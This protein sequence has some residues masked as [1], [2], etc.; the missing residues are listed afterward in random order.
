MEGEIMDGTVEE[1]VAVL[2]KGSEF[3][4]PEIK[5]VMTQEL[6]ERLSEA[7]AKGRPLRVYCGYDATRPDLHLGHTITLRKLRQFQAFGHEATFLIGDFT[8]RVG[9]PSDRDGSRPQLD[10]EEI[11][12]NARTYAEQAFKI[13]DPECTRV[14]YNSEWLAQLDLVDAIQIASR[15][16]VQQ[17]LARENFQARLERRDPIWLHEFFY[18]LF[19]GYDAVAL[20]T[21]VQLGAT[22]QL[23]NLL[24]GRKLQE[25]FGQRPQVCI[26]FPVLVGT[27]GH[28]RMSK[29][30]GNYIGIAEPPQVMYGKVMSIPDGAMSSYFRLV[31]RWSA[32]RVAQLEADL[33]AGH[34]HPME[35][36]KTLAWEIVDCYHDSDV[37]DAAARHFE[38]VHQ[39]H[40]QPKEMPEF[41]IGE[42]MAIP[43]LLV[44][45]GI[46]QSK[47][48]GR[49]LVQ[50]GG[51]KIDGK[52]V[53]SVDEV[54]TPGEMVLQVGRRR[55]VHLVPLGLVPSGL[56]PLG[57]LPPG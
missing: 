40:K 15:F 56:V 3:G 30:A 13:L 52:P 54:V 44:A 17:F 11:A 51:V 36:K 4:D 22:E 55:F 25:A 53:E 37:A 46:C 7:Q 45:A 35:A 18:A 12:E 57:L 26:T 49:R 41:P 8:T 33:A 34:L 20:R 47:S 19:Q 31:T 50:Q 27:D 1:Q 48:Q 29:S 39:Q 28:T 23:F 24:A 6:R 2:M 5:A 9:D 32:E 14:R 21:D 43:E 10:E 16:T 38:R 42:P